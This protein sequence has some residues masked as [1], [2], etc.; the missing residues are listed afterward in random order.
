L[1]TQ[2]KQQQQWGFMG[3][4]TPRE[5]GVAKMG[6]M[7]V[8]VGCEEECEYKSERNVA[9]HFILRNNSQNCQSHLSVAISMIVLSLVR[10]NKKE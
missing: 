7:V 8:V 10:G 1:K 4:V 5:I 2:S 9:Q 6:W 3:V